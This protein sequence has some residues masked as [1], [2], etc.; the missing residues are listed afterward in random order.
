MAKTDQQKQIEKNVERNKARLP[1]PVINP[2]RLE[3]GGTVGPAV[4]QE[5]AEPLTDEDIA[6]EAEES[7]E[8]SHPAEDGK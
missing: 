8:A 6:T 7:H 5:P 4:Y 2:R 1:E 3:A